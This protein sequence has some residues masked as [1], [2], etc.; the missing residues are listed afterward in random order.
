[1][2]VQ[3]RF[4][5]TSDRDLVEIARLG[6]LEAYDELVGRF[7]NAVVMVA[8]QVLGSREAAHDVAQEAFMLAYQALPRLQDPAKFAGWLYAIAR[9]RARRVATRD[10]R[11]EVTESSSL[12]RLM[13]A[14]YGDQALSP[15]DEL[16][17]AERL[18]AIRGL[19]ADL[20]PD[21]QIVLQLF[22]Y[23]QWPAARIAEFLALPLTTVKWRLHSGRN[24]LLSRLAELM[25]E[26]P[27]GREERITPYANAAA[28][29]GRDGPKR[30]TDR[31]L[32]KRRPQL[33]ETVQ[34]D[35]GAP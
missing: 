23:E 32:R 1:M 13:T 14:H 35:C 4:Q 9:N 31:Q 2:A 21:I 12:E 16:L 17:R 20:S 34:C 33:R 11:S 5:Y 3:R 22:Y 10:S 27:D 15:L 24:R 19:V 6:S 7:R 8:D 18:A 25:E 26:K 29:D 30:R 28:E